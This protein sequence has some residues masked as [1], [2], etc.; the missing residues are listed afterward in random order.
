MNS[1]S[2]SC[3]RTDRIEMSPIVRY[4]VTAERPAGIFASVTL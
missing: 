4:V 1:G 3:I 2:G